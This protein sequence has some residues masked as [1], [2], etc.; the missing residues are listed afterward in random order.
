MDKTVEEMQQVLVKVPLFN[1]LLTEEARKLK[2]L[3][4]PTV[5]NRINVVEDDANEQILE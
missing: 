1:P 4:I 5:M 2:L 3:P